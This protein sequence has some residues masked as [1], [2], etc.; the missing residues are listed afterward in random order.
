[1]RL[2][3]GQVGFIEAS[4]LY[5]TDAQGNTIK[6]ATMKCRAQPQIRRAPAPGAGG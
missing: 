4:T 6:A 1:L 3:A 5:V 2:P